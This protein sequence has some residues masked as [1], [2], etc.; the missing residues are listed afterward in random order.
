MAVIPEWSYLLSRLDARLHGPAV[1]PFDAA[2]SRR[3]RGGNVFSS[4]LSA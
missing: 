3:V 1:T 2:L 4:R